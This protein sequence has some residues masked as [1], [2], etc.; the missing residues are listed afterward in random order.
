[1]FQIYIPGSGKSTMGSSNGFYVDNTPLK[2]TNIYHIDLDFNNYEPIG[3]QGSNST[4]MVYWEGVEE[5]SQVWI[6]RKLLKTLHLAV[7]K[8]FLKFYMH[9]LGYM[10]F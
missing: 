2:I 1:M 3:F 6:M 7:L 4:I 8:I 9:E 10:T 5:E